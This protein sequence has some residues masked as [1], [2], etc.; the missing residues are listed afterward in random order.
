ML[1]REAEAHAPAAV[2][3]QP[4]IDGSA[5]THLGDGLYGCTSLTSVVDSP[6][7]T[8]IEIKQV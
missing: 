3:I 8:S 1:W 6:S 5:V 7:V 4:T 2:T